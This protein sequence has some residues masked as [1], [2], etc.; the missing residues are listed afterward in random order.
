MQNLETLLKNNPPA[1]PQA[2]AYM[3]YKLA[4]MKYNSKIPGVWPAGQPKPKP[5]QPPLTAQGKKDV[6]NFQ[7][8]MNTIN[9]KLNEGAT[10]TKAAQAKLAMAQAK[11]NNDQ[12]ALVKAT[13]ALNL[14]NQEQAQAINTQ[15][16]Y[17]AKLA[18]TI[19]NL[20]NENYVS[21]IRGAAEAGQDFSYY[22]LKHPIINPMDMYSKNAIQ[23]TGFAPKFKQLPTGVSYVNGQPTIT[24]SVDTPVPF[25]KIPMPDVPTIGVPPL[26]VSAPTSNPTPVINPTTGVVNNKQNVS[27]R[28]TT[29]QQNLSPLIPNQTTQPTQS[30]PTNPFHNLPFQPSD[31][32]PVIP[33]GGAISNINPKNLNPTSIIDKIGGVLGG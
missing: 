23:N 9:D 15:Q 21:N 8:Q 32:T 19:Q 1:D 11:Q 7:S 5:V 27:P 18:N 13:N 6:A 2:K 24:G 14:A 31:I 28:N 30:K 25:N 26:P 4:L 17:D 12:A 10:N 22:M 20:Y 29:P 3:E 33:G 16:N